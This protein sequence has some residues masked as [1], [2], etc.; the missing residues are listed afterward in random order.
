MNDPSNAPKARA[1]LAGAWAV[2]VAAVL[3][4]SGPDGPPAWAWLAAFEEAGGDKLVHGGLFAV[5]A[6][7]LCRSRPAA[8]GAGW[9][10][11]CLAAAVAYGALT[12]A[13]QLLLAAR[14]GDLLDLAADALGAGLGAGAY[15]AARWWRQR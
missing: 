9:L 15:A 4:T 10:L 13:V 6:W 14:E 3:W 5:Q 8:S 12:E 7:L 1:V 2:L 11:G